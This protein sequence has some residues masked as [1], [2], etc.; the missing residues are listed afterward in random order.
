MS[1]GIAYSKSKVYAC[2]GPIR[3]SPLIEMDGESAG[4]TGSAVSRVALTLVVVIVSQMAASAQQAWKA[5]RTPDGYPDLQGVWL[6]NRATPLERPAS[7]VRQTISHPRRSQ[8]TEGARCLT[9]RP[10]R[11]PG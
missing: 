8:G 1:L 11:L 10:P 4:D 9:Y 5:P 7:E 3:A 6:A 2:L